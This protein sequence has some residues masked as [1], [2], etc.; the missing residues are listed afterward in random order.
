MKIINA[1][2]VE[3]GKTVRYPKILEDRICDTCGKLFVPHRESSNIC[4]IGCKK[5]AVYVSKIINGKRIREFVVLEDR[6]C[7]TCGELFSP[8]TQRSIFCSRSCGKKGDRL[9]NKEKYNKKAAD[10]YLN[11]KERAKK[12]R[13]EYYYNNQ[14]AF[15]EYGKKWRLENKEKKSKTEKEYHDKTRHGSKKESSISENG[16]KC[17]RCGVKKDNRFDIIMHHK[18][19][20]NQEHEHQELLCRSCHAKIHMRAKPNNLKEVTKEEIIKAIESTKNLFDACKSLGICRAT[21]YDKRKKFN[22]I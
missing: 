5:K 22:L 18:T 19:F 7:A 6:K 21:L 13:K 20:N 4:S 8:K 16:L 3:N 2:K 12:Q 15:Y 9:K 1:T 14:E 11:N 10:W 17:S